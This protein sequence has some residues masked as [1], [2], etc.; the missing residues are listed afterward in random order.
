MDFLI[1]MI[2]VSI[3]A[4]YAK[5]KFVADNQVKQK[6][7]HSIIGYSAGAI[8][9]FSV[10]VIAKDILSVALFFAVSGVASLECW[11]IYESWNGSAP[12]Q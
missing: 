4:F 11:K 12:K 7:I 8:A 1:S 5:E 6:K 2:F 9:S 3:I 10:M